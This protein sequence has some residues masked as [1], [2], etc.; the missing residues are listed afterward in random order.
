MKRFLVTST[1]LLCSLLL[2]NCKKDPQP[3]NQCIATPFTSGFKT[4]LVGK[5]RFFKLPIYYQSGTFKEYID[6]IDLGDTYKIEILE[7]G[8]IDYYKNDI[9]IESKKIEVN[10]ENESNGADHMGVVT[11]YLNCQKEGN[12][13]NYDFGVLLKTSDTLLANYLPIIINNSE[14]GEISGRGYYYKMP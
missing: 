5:W 6:T 7:C 10:F 9:L 14:T 3:C 1:T 12:V 8:I 11:G 2:L 4:N 13:E